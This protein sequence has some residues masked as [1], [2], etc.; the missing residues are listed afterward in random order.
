M[1]DCMTSCRSI[2]ILAG[3]IS[4]KIRKTRP[5]AAI[6]YMLFGFYSFCVIESGVR[7]QSLPLR[8]VGVNMM[9]YM[10]EHHR[11]L[12]KYYDAFIIKSSNII[13]DTARDIG[14]GAQRALVRISPHVAIYTNPKYAKLLGAYNNK[15]L[16]EDKRMLLAV[17]NLIFHPQAIYEM[18]YDIV[19]FIIERAPEKT[20]DEF[21]VRFKK[22]YDNTTDLIALKVTQQATKI[23]II[24]MIARLIATNL[25]NKAAVIAVISKITKTSLTAF[26]I[27]GLVTKAGLAADKLRQQDRLIYNLLYSK[28][29][30]MLYFII[31]PQISP[32]I[33]VT[34]INDHTNADALIEAL[35]TLFHK[36]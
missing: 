2:P 12:E 5:S 14:V 7:V 18:S 22:A 9:E 27:Y 8:N 4:R 24:S 10:D 25:T 35:A 3:A 11:V 21:I 29:S 13:K 36:D 31:E 1:G 33:Y 17:S 34:K 16:K 6:P 26:Q 30:E 23:A 28:N 19:K 15:I 32:L 20:Q